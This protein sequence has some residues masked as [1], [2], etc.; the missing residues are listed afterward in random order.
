MLAVRIGNAPIT[1]ARMVAA[2]IANRRQAWTLRPS[3][4][5]TNQMMSATTR[6]AHRATLPRVRIVGRAAVPPEPSSASL[7]SECGRVED[8][9]DLLVR[10]DVLAAHEL[11][12][13]L[14]GLHRFRSQLGRSLVPDDRVQRRGRPDAV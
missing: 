3:G 1:T 2:K 12:D 7:A 10:Q 9:I 6:V 4:G 11:D 13:P 5:G 14:S 8:L